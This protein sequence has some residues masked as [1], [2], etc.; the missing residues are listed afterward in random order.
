MTARSSALGVLL[1]RTTIEDHNEVL[2]AC[3]ATLRESKGDNNAQFVKI[4]ALIKEDRYDDALRTLE[5][6][7]DQIKVRARLQ[8]AYVLYK[9]GRQKEARKVLG[10]F[11]SDRGAKHLEA[12]AAYRSED[13][14]HAARLYK[15]LAGGRSGLG[16]EVND[17]R[18][19]VGATDAQLEWNR[20]GELVKSKRA[21]REDLETF[22]T[23]Y[24]AAC[25]STARG[26]L[27]QAQFL[28]K[29]AKG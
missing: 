18:I 20:Q 1:S 14:E 4:V 27:V 16:D 26:E 19:Q 17:L 29:R 23:A 22:E 10:G 13:F 21:S 28:L 2:R 3:D 8:H 9:T 11:D 12:Q 6:G 15:E 24:N 7:G 25:G 5:D